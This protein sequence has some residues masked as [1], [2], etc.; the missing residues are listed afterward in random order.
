MLNS[1]MGV[2]IVIVGVLCGGKVASVRNVEITTET[3][4]RSRN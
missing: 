1:N 2:D 4:L 3:I